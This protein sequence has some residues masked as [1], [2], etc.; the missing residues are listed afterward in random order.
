[1][2]ARIVSTLA[3]WWSM[4]VSTGQCVNTTSGFSVVTSFVIAATCPWVIS[5]APSI[6]P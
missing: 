4:C 5:V 1:M 2:Q 3:T 6:W